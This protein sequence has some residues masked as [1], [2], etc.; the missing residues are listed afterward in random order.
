MSADRIYNKLANTSNAAELEHLRLSIHSEPDALPCFL[1]LMRRAGRRG[2]IQCYTFSAPEIFTFPLNNAAACTVILDVLDNAIRARYQ[3]LVLDLLERALAVLAGPYLRYVLKCSLMA[4]IRMDNGAFVER[5]LKAD[6]DA[7]ILIDCLDKA[8]CEMQM[9]F[10]VTI[11]N[12]IQASFEQ[13]LKVT[14]PAAETDAKINETVYHLDVIFRR[15][16]D[17]GVDALPITR[18]LLPLYATCKRTGALSETGGSLP[19]PGV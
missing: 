2:N 13:D 5:A 6:F 18:A 16:A 7:T 11:A 19:L 14:P 12:Y 9:N 1:E 10:V 15:N 4:A 17:V 8:S 3:W